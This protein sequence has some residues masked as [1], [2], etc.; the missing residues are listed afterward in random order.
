MF[1]PPDF[2]SCDSSLRPCP[3]HLLRYQIPLI[4]GSR[5]ASPSCALLSTLSCPPLTNS[6]TSNLVSSFAG[7]ESFVFNAANIQSVTLE[8]LTIDPLTRSRPPRRD[9]AWRSRGTK[10]RGEGKRGRG[11]GRRIG[12]ISAERSGRYLARCQYG[13]PVSVLLPERSRV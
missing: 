3:R 7:R 11:H 5:N 13:K 12:S 6:A 8:S 4:Q 10:S 2:S 1:S 9:K